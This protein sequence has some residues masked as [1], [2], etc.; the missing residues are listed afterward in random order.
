MK[1]SYSININGEKHVILEDVEQDV[2]DIN[3]LERLLK[4][5]SPES[6]KKVKAL[7]NSTSVITELRL[8][9]INESAIGV[10]SPAELINQVASSINDARLLKNLTISDD[11]LKSKIVIAGFGS[12]NVPSQFKDGHLFLNLN[13]LYDY[14]NKIIALTELAIHNKF[15]GSKSSDIIKNASSIRE[16][17]NSDNES[18]ID[19]LTGIIKSAYFRAGLK[20]STDISEDKVVTERDNIQNTYNQFKTDNVDENYSP[21]E[22]V[23]VENLKPGDLVLIPIDSA[24]YKNGVYEM[25]YDRDRKSTRLNSSH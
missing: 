13:Y 1:C 17:I 18:I 19:R 21:K 5:Q 20:L 2:K 8:D 22:K 4:R 14:D 11:T 10:Y 23:R 16:I 24:D 25:F 6:L 7:L 9:D 12:E 15:P 3:D